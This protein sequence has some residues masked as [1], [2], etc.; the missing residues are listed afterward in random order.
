M[1]RFSW[2]FLPLSYLYVVYNDRQAVL[3]GL[4][5]TARSLIVKVSWLRQM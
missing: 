1:C 5:P 4:T 3:N 2:E